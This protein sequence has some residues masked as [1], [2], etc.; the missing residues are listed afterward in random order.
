MSK[1][2]NL[3]Y[4]GRFS[5]R[6]KRIDRLLEISKILELHNFDYNFKIFSDVD[7]NSYEYK[8]FKNNSNFNFLGYKI[9]WTNYIDESSIMVMVSEYEG[10][11]LSILEAYKYNLNKLAVLNM[12]GIE[13]YISNNCIYADIEHMCFAFINKADL[14]NK[15]NISTYFDET[16]FNNEVQDFYFN[17]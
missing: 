10:C 2:L 5:Y 1:M 4:V 16:R 3:Y 12:P 17:I 9:D 14:E 15:K 7:I 11:P 6:Q 8:M 13:C